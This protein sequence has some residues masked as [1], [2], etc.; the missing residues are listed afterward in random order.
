MK[1]RN[2]K[3]VLLMA[4]VLAL[5]GAQAGMAEEAE[6]E[7]ATEAAE[8]A[9]E[10]P[11]TE[12]KVR[13]TYK[14]SD[15]VTLGD[16]TGLSVSVDTTVSELEIDD[17]VRINLQQ[18]GLES[19]ELTEGTVQ[20]GDVAN[21]D[22]EGKKDG[23]PFENG[24]A[25]GY[26]LEIGSGSFI[27]GFEEGLIG[28]AIGDTVDLPLTFPE[29]YH[30]EKLAGADVVFTVTVNSVKRPKELT[31]EL[32]SEL[33]DGETT[34]VA[35]Y[36]SKVMDELIQEKKDNI[37]ETANAYLYQ[38]ISGNS[39]IDGYPEEV[40]TYEAELMKEYY[41]E[42]AAEYGMEF[43]DFLASFLGM[44]EEQFEAQAVVYAQ[45]AMAQELLMNAIAEKEQLELTD[46]E[47][48]QE[49]K[50]FAAK[51]GYESLEDLEAA[52][53]KDGVRYAIQQDKVM[54]FLRENNEIIEVTGE[55]A[56][57]DSE[58]EMETDM[59]LSE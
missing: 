39:T 17:R 27:D 3:A 24:T 7:A 31:D 26:D 4:G 42:Y 53:G 32:V 43:A 44:T 11:E 2:L 22:Y 30:S 38:L 5:A 50:D 37:N 33:T 52:Y 35:A 49:G 34:S 48:A 6:T 9:A 12:A 45:S 41:Q 13:P 14:A 29:N 47:Y 1:K 20:S 21:I 40:V 23:V 10:T 15:Y 59:T 54:E 16:Y 28:V 19:E 58:T 8:A 55:E 46:E 56:E 51:Y 36:R 25:E 57:S 18:A